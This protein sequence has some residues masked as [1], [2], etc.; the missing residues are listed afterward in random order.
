M[1]LEE[2][3]T[4]PL[5]PDWDRLLASREV[6]ALWSY[7]TWAAEES[8]LALSV[9]ALQPE[10][11]DEAHPLPVAPMALRRGRGTAALIREVQQCP[12]QMRAG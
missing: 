1:E 2:R 4:A 12:K 10:E 6:A 8:L 11:V 3:L 7:R 9:P 5:Q